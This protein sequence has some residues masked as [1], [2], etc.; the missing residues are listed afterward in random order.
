[1]HRTVLTKG[2][3]M[4]RFKNKIQIA[5]LPFIIKNDKGV[6]NHF[7]LWIYLYYIYIFV[8]LFFFCCSCFSLSSSYFL[9][10]PSNY[11]VTIVITIMFINITVTGVLEKSSGGEFQARNSSGMAYPYSSR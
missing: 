6:S 8:F 10:N 7:F 3:S 2:M 11:T 5:C 4:K 1:M 9:F